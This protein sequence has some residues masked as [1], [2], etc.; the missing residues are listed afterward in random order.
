MVQQ[1]I[2]IEWWCIMCRKQGTVEMW[3]DLCEW[4]AINQ[5]VRAHSLASPG[6]GADARTSLRWRPAEYASTTRRGFTERMRHSLEQMH[7]RGRRLFS[8]R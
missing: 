8:G 5:L 7:Q 2:K 6:C 1:F 3:D 4:G